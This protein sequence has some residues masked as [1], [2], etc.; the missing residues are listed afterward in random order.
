MKHSSSNRTRLETGVGRHHHHHP[1]PSLLFFLSRPKV[2]FL[3][4]LTDFS[5]Q[6]D[7]TASQPANPSISFS[8]SLAPSFPKAASDLISSAQRPQLVS[9]TISHN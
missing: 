5:S 8:R 7:K 4:Q 1:N 3:R 2:F 6:P 9:R